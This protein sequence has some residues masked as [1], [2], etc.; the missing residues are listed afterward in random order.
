MKRDTVRRPISR[1]PSVVGD[2]LHGSAPPI[3]TRGSTIAATDG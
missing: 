2:H 1:E 3:A